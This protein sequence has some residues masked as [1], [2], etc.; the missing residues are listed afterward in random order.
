MSLEC[1]SFVVL[2]SDPHSPLFSILYL[3][4]K[5]QTLKQVIKQPRNRLAL[6][7]T[8]RERINTKSIRLSVIPRI[9]QAPPETLLSYRQPCS[10]VTQE[11]SPKQTKACRL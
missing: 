8:S 7:N 3:L 11:H 5:D 4:P 9:A 2:Q 6:L 1:S 10:V